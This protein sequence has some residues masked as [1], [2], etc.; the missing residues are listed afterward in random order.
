MLSRLGDDDCEVDWSSGETFAWWVWIAN[1]EVLRDI[2]GEGVYRVCATVT[3]GVKAV[4]VN[5]ARGKFCIT[6]NKQTGKMIVTPP[7]NPWHQ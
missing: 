7:P 2:G 3:K 5:S 1:T 4:V 6:S